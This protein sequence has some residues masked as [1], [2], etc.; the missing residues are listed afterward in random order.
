MSVGTMAMAQGFYTSFNVGYGFGTPGDAVGTE[1]VVDASLNS[2]ET[3]VY[4]S[5]GGG[6]NIGLNPGYMFNEHIGAELGLNYLLG[7]AVTNYD[8]TSPF[9]TSLTESKSNQFRISP[10][11]VLTTGGDKF[12]V[13]GKAGLVLPVAGST[14]TRT[15]TTPIIG[16][17]STQEMESKGALSL[18]FQGALGV[19]YKMSEK[20]S[21][22]GELSHV[23]LRIKGKTQ[24]VTE[25][26]VAGVDVLSAMTI[27]QKETVYVD[28]INA[29]SNNGSN[30]NQNDGA[31]R[32][33]LASTSNYNALFINIGVKFNF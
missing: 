16:A 2:T 26:M 25:N 13:Y 21:L 32:E 7:S 29:S 27:Y 31:A 33:A 1:E 17:A 4:G 11:I 14:I 22:F 23:S 5:F 3:N 15:E 9:A 12:E 30:P 20:L 19:G 18:G 24:S 6:I 8:L 10:S 28:E